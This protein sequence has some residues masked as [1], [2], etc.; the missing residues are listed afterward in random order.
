MPYRLANVAGRAALVAGD[1]YYDLAALSNGALGPDP[2]AAIAAC[3][4]LHALSAGLADR[5]PTGS[6]ADAELGS[7]VPSPR[8][9]FAVGLNYATHVAESGMET[10][11]APVIFSK[12]PSCIV[13]PDADI[14][15]NSAFGDYEA[16][17]V[18]VIGA[19]GANIAA[20]D[21]WMHVAGITGG[22]DISDR[23]LQFAA[24]PAHFDLGKSRD[25]YGPVGPVLVS[26]DSFDDPDDIALACR[27][28]GEERQRSSTARLIFSVPYLVEYLSAALTLAPGDLIFT[29]TPDG[30]GVT[31][32]T[33]LVDGDE[34]VTEI[35]GV[36]T[37][38][39]RC[40]G[41][42]S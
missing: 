22:Q 29:G 31:S 11:A 24:T 1:G 12:F 19:G 6:L 9:S 36:G 27:V 32:G 18:V 42:A 13:G 26:P 10:P 8:N 30:V 21:V 2:M 38:T 34:I 41:G 5:E 37:L 28:N 16:E 14:A 25:T 3:D 15:L 35:A 23:N 20:A 40:V 17:V 7:P 39:N 33:F 4:R